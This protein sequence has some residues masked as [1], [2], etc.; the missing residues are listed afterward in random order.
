MPIQAGQEQSLAISF[1]K[2]SM[3]M[4]KLCVDDRVRQKEI[5][6]HICWWHNLNFTWK[7]FDLSTLFKVP[8]VLSSMYCS[9]QVN[10][11]TTCR[12]S[13]MKDGRWKI[14][15]HQVHECI[16]ELTNIGQHNVILTFCEV[17][18]HKS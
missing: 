7:N 4:E 11:E 16:T 6:F 2:M 14:Q 8:Q 9:H 3:K 5:T 12:I 17:R 1:L 10:L 18:I 13:L 15:M